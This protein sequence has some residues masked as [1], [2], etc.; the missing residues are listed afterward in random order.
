MS[1]PDAGRDPTVPGWPARVL[2]LGVRLYQWT[3]SPLTGGQCR[4]SP[5]C[6]RYAEE[7]LREHGAGRGAWLT[8]RRLARCHPFCK[9]G[10]DPVPPRSSSSRT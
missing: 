3:L 5:T 7:A 4:F 10:Y 8:A 6:S 9:G 1:E 2:I